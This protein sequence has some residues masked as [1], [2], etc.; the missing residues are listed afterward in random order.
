MGKELE[1]ALYDMV[2]AYCNKDEELPH[3]FEIKALENAR[4]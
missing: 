1:K 4:I 3:S 2:I